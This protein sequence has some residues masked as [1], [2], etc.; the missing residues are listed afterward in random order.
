MFRY[1]PVSLAFLVGIFFIG[2]LI[3]SMILLNIPYA[4]QAVIKALIMII[5]VVLD[6][7]S[8]RK[9]L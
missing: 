7:R 6:V 5:S 1:L 4:Y 2:I 8:R 9:V 3:N